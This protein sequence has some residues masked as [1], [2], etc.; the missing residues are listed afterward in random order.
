MGSLPKLDQK[1]LAT[2][3]M[4]GTVGGRICRIEGEE[5]P[6]EVYREENGKSRVRKLYGEAANMILVAKNGTTYTVDTGEG[7][8]FGFGD[9]FEFNGNYYQ[10]NIVGGLQKLTEQQR[11]QVLEKIRNASK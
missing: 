8:V 4:D 10:L 3:N 9:H 11:D 5:I 2:K 6:Y 7:H 1:D